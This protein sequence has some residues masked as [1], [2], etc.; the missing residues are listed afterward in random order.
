MLPESSQTSATILLSRLLADDARPADAPVAFGRAGT[1]DVADFRSRVAALAGQLSAAGRGYWLLYTT[2]AYA[3]AVALAALV[4]SGSTAVLAPNGERGTLTELAARVTGR[5]LPP[6]LAERLP[7]ALPTLDPLSVD[8]GESTKLEAPDRLRPAIELF[9]SGTTGDGKPVT[10]ALAHLEDEVVVLERRFGALLGPATRMF[11]TVSCQHLYG[12]LFRVLW[13]LVSGRPFQADTLL[14]PEELLPRMLEAGDCALAATPVHLQR[15]GAPA[16][17]EPL[18]SVCRVVFSSGGPLEAETAGAVAHGLGT[19]PVEIFGSTETGGVAWRRREVNDTRDG[20]QWTPLD[21]VSI[22]SEPETSRLV[23]RS[24]F[25]SVGETCGEQ[26]GSGADRRA[27]L[28]YTMG[29]CVRLVAGGGFELLGRFDRVVKVGEKRLSLPDMERHLRTH[30]AVADAVAFPFERAGATRLRAVVSLSGEGR[31]ML[32]ER[33]HRALAER[34]GGHL[35]PYF[36]RVVL[37][38]AWRFVDA[39]PRDAQGK[40]SVALLAGLFE[41]K[42]AT[43]VAAGTAATDGSGRRTSSLKQAAPSFPIVRKERR[44]ERT[45]E[46][47]LH[48][49]ADLTFLEGHF[50]GFPI[51]A[52]VVQV[53]WV[54]NAAREILGYDPE[55]RAMEALKF[56]DLLTPGQ[57]FD[58]KVE[59]NESRDRVYFVLSD[60]A[61]VF[62]SGRCLLAPPVCGEPAA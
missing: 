15:L 10:K 14:R 24:P 27:M 47:R 53:H 36:D 32:A 41:K 46:R 50:D 60:D 56:K 33:G 25:V 39:L 40:S 35:A 42:P 62:S 19:A 43:A 1:Y 2:D 57:D 13:P 45:L 48:V 23:V 6:V 22:H 20:S 34:L 21:G 59:V 7:S 8:G 38:R 9:T 58:M 49:P 29:D 31:G 51:V 44:G 55:L 5:L 37:P 4:H 28:E 12:L 17:V 18:R 3:F 52:G 30:P 61:R 26:T 11:S 16:G 54:M